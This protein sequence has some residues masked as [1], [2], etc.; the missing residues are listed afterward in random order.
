[1]R[2]RRERKCRS[3]AGRTTTAST[4]PS[5]PSGAWRCRSRESCATTATGRWPRSSSSP[6]RRNG[7][8]SRAPA[9][10]CCFR[11]S[12]GR[13]TQ[14]PYCH[15]PAVSDSA[16][17]M[18]SKMFLSRRIAIATLA[19][20]SFLVCTPAFAQGSPT[21]VISQVYGGGGNSGATYKNDFIEIFNRGTAAVFLGSMSLQY[22]S[23]TG[24]LGGSNVTL[25]PG[26]TLQPGQ[27]FL[28][29]EAAG[30]GGTT[31]LPAP[32]V[33]TGTINMS[34]TGGKVALVNSTASL[35]CSSTASCAAVAS[36][37]VDL[38]GYDGA[39]F[40][41]GSGTAP[42]LS[43]TTAAFRAGGGC[44]DTDDNKADFSAGA[45]VPRNASSPLRDCAQ[46]TSPT[47][48]ASAS[49]STVSSGDSTTLTVTVSPGAH[50]A[51]TGIAVSGDL[52]SIG[53]SA[54]QAFIDNG[55][56]TFTWLT[57]VSASAGAKTI[58]VSVSDAQG[59]STTASIA[60]TVTPPVPRVAIHDIQGAALFSPWAGQLV[61]TEGVVTSVKANGYFIQAPDD[62]ADSDPNTPEGIFVFTSS[63]PPS[64]A[65]VHN[66]VRV[67]AKVQD[68]IPASDPLSPPV[69]EL[70]NSTS[71]TAL[72]G[73]NPLP[74]AVALT[75]ADF[76]PAGSIS[77][78]SKYEGMRV[79]VDTI[80]VIAPSG[81]FINEANATSTSNGTFYGVLPGTPRPFREPGIEAPAPAP[82]GV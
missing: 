9:D 38:V 73:G 68:F 70:A 25:L 7:A 27:Y 5:P 54:A 4:P 74:A 60:L 49:P 39:T 76:D 67:R 17:H 40:F 78:L 51:S 43:N 12:L 63:A 66:R 55:S 77:Q 30:A 50:P 45:P 23:T 14:F 2:F 71:V 26:V 36:L 53:G 57:A 56:G 47:A 32:D 62:E 29:R 46:P 42:T 61:Q 31:D 52:S 13:N 28:V 19:I 80:N 6:A 75:S 48:S 44:S 11:G 16:P 8:R 20:A 24:N 72:S 18:N 3:S 64:A 1:M 65:A 10:T 59:R 37:I 15:Y 33:T 79:H 22:G 82:S 34:A 81:G 41:E 69:T 21:L 35:G 58:P